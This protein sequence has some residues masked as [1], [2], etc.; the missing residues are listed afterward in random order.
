MYETRAGK[1]CLLNIIAD[2]ASSNNNAD[3]QKYRN[4]EK[5]IERIK[6]FYKIY[7]I[8]KYFHSENIA[9][10]DLMEFMIEYQRH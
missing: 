9:K 5:N 4:D 1:K 8:A 6:S 10:Y 2:D 7:F 3:R